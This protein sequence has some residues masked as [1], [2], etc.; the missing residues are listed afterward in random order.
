MIAV[1][2]LPGHL[3]AALV[4]IIV[5]NVAG[6][7]AAAALLWLGR[8][9][10]QSCSGWASCYSNPALAGQVVTA[11]LLW[12]GKLLQQSCSGWASCYS[13]P[14]LAHQVVIAVQYV[15]AIL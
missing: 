5:L 4:I 1:Q 3:V 6:K 7:V 8:L 11:I 15:T 14:A 12:L 10:Q 2:L 13:N 9:L